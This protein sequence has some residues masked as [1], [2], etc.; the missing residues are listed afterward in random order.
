MNIY[1]WI[2]QISSYVGLNKFAKNKF[3]IDKQLQYNNF[4]DKRPKKCCCCKINNFN[5]VF[6]NII[7]TIGGLYQLYQY[8]YF[9]GVSSILV[10]IG[11]AYYHLNPNMNTLFYDRLP[12]QFAFT[13]II[14]DKIKINLIEKLL[15]SLISFGS[16]YYWSYNYDLIPYASFQLSMIIYWLLFDNNMFIPV[17]FYILAKICEDNDLKIFNLTNKK[18]SG[19]TIK[20]ILSGI[21]IFFI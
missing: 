2:I 4:A 20:H 5:D 15:V 16:L 14:Y 6:S 13:Y 17:I 8:N 12:M 3:T 7:Y 19:H 18:I 21:A 1:F 10:S 9:L 11:S